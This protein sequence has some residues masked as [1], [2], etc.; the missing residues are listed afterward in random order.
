MIP[1]KKPTVCNICGGEVEYIPNRKLYG[2]ALGSGYCYHCTSCGAYVGTH[3][4]RPKEA[5]GILSN[6]RMRSGKS[7]CHAMFDKRWRSAPNKRKARTQQYEWL[8]EQMG[9]PVEECHFGY[10]DLEQLRQ[11]YR[12]LRNDEL[13]RY[14]LIRAKLSEEK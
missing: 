1:P 4:P 5:M 13:A 12:I 14:E 8:A 3:K 6:A 9:I 2:K 11:A 7:F 10:F